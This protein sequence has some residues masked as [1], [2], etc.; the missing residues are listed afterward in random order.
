MVGRRNELRRLRF[1]YETWLISYNHLIQIY[2]P[3]SPS[4]TNFSHTT[5]SLWL[6]EASSYKPLEGALFSHEILDHGSA[7]SSHGA[8]PSGLSGSGS[9]EWEV[10]TS[11]RL[12]RK[13]S[14]FTFSND[15]LKRKPLTLSVESLNFIS[16]LCSE[17][18]SASLLWRKNQVNVTHC[19]EGKIR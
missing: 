15:E 5:A 1:R 11:I 12:S 7:I 3:N 9:S 14:N 18:N 17:N 2:V 4:F 10:G 6:P 16:H 13:E 19:Y 8:P